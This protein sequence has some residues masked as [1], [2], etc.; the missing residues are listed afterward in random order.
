MT[1]DRA[2][3]EQLYREYWRC[4]IE[5]DADG[6]RGMMAKDYFLLHMTGTRQSADEFL[7][8]LSRGTFQ[9][10][11]AGHDAI[12]VTLHGDTAEMIGRSRVEAA[13]YGGGRHLWRLRGDFTLRKEDGAWKLVCSRASTY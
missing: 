9:Y 10:F 3:I 12:D 1:D 7:R 5:K 8:G 2:E 4:M 6:L 11:S 13:V